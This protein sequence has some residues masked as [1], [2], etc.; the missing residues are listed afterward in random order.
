MRT[1]ITGATGLLGANLAVELLR[2]GHTVRATR[3]ASS[4]VS[5]LEGIAIEWVDAGLDSADRLADAFRGADVA[6]HCAAQVGVTRRATAA[7]SA[8]NVDGTRHVL[9]AVKVA[10]VRR[11]VHC[12]TVACVAL[13][14]D[15]TPTGEDAEYNFDMRGMA[16]GYGRTKREAEH[17]VQQA[18]QGGL[19]AVI[20]SP[21]YMFGPYDVRP[22]SGQ[23]IVD[24]VRGKVPGLTRGKNNF[25][26]ARD[27]ARGMILVAERGRTGER[28][29]LGGENMTYAEVTQRIARVA[30]VGAPTWYVPRAIAAP[31]GWVGDLREALG[32]GPLIT[33]VTLAFAYCPDFV[34]SSDK[35]RR[36]LGYTTGPVDD[37]IRDAVGWFRERGVLS[38]P[39]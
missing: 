14:S 27:V 19:D 13:S 32:G 18:A 4:D 35:A 36:E 34:F 3:R 20:A 37:A 22:S 15:G 6:F 17:L 31:I 26:D 1:A 10:G 25:V 38:R 28:Y 9:E 23:L 30:G 2:A 24:V 16:D 29:I 33:S 7:M 8:A 21:C 11:L 12:S 5:H 39:G